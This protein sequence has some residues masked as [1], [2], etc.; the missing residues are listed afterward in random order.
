MV[1]LP[2]AQTSMAK[3]PTIPVAVAPDIWLQNPPIV[4]AHDGRLRV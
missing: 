3:G 1:A 4:L 2:D